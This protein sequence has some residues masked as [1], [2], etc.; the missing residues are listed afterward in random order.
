MTTED[1]LNITVIYFVKKVTISL[2]AD[3]IGM[4]SLFMFKPLHDLDLVISKLV[5]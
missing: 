4:S 1:V 5:M 2:R 3:D